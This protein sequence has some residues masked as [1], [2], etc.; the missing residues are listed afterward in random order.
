MTAASGDGS[1]MGRLRG[2][3]IWIGFVLLAVDAAIRHLHG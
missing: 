3:A 1:I 2:W